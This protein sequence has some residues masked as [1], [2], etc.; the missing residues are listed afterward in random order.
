MRNA[1][2]AAA[3]AALMLPAT[4]QAADEK[5]L[6]CVADHLDAVTVAAIESYFEDTTT[7]STSTGTSPPPDTMVKA[8]KAAAATCAT[9]HGWSVAA[10]QAAGGYALASKGRA[11]AERGL[12]S[13]GIDPAPIAHM[14]LQLPLSARETLMPAAPWPSELANFSRRADARHLYPV[15]EARRVGRYLGC[16][17]VID[18]FRA[19]FRRD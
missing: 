9:L 13:L 11:G 3:F 6:G 16:L 18:A 15:A 8:V 7:A 10:T 17:N 4:A 5:T 1:I 14:Y 12:H 19:K 2:L